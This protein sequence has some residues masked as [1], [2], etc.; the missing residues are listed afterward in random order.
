MDW[1]VTWL[2]VIAI[3]TVI[4]SLSVAV[5]VAYAL[6]LLSS[7]RTTAQKLDLTLDRMQRVGGELEQITS[8][9][10]HMEERV[11]RTVDPLLDQ[12]LPPIRGLTAILAGVRTGLGALA[13][14]KKNDSVTSRSS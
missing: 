8:R 9:F 6:P 12:T 5:L 4:F 13:T 11:A 1:S 14:W 7:M 3:A 10:R 2:G